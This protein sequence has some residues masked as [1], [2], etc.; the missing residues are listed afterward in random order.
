MVRHTLTRGAF[1]AAMGIALTIGGALPS[2][3]VARAE[4]APSAGPGAPAAAATDTTEEVV[5]PA[6]F[7]TTP[8]GG[9]PYLAERS[10]YREADAAGTEGVFHTE[11]GLAGTQWTRYAD[12]KTVPVTLPD[13]PWTAVQGTG[14]DVLAYLRAG[15]V[16]LRHADGTVRTVALPDGLD[17]GVRV[18]GSTVVAHKMVAKPDGTG[19]TATETHLLSVRPDGTTLD[20]PVTD[21][22]GDGFLGVPYDA[23]D[24]HVLMTTYAPGQAVQPALVSKETGRVT[25]IGAPL[26]TGAYPMALSPRHVA[27]RSADGTVL[28]L[29]RSDLAAPPVPV[30]L[31][32]ALAESQQVAVV[33]EQLV[34]R[35]TLGK[36]YRQPI[37]GGAAV[38]LVARSTQAL[39]TGPDG[40]AV[41]I[42]GSG[43]TDW[44]VRRI[45][46][47]AEGRPV[48]ALVK[49]FTP[50]TAHIRGIAITQGRLA[51]VDDSASAAGKAGAHV[52][53]VSAAGIGERARFAG[54]LPA[55]A[56]D[57]TA[58][59]RLIGLGDG[60]FARFSA[61]DQ[62]FDTYAVAGP[63]RSTVATGEK[64]SLLTDASPHQLLHTIPGPTGENAV[65]D[66]TAN[67]LR[68]YPP[69][70]T[71]LHGSANWAASTTDKGTVVRRFV[72]DAD[73]IASYPGILPCVAQELQVVGRWMYWLCGPNGPAGVRDM[74]TGA[75]RP[76]PSGEALLGDGYV[77]THDKTAGKLV[78]TGVDSSRT[79]SRVIGDL[80]DTG[81][82]Q[83]HIRWT[84]D[85]FGGGAAYVDAA[86][87]VRLVPA[88]IATQPLSVVDG[89]GAD[90]VDAT[91][92]APMLTTLT[93]SK[94]V[95]SWNLSIRHNA[96]GEVTAL[97]AGGEARERI[98]IRWNGRDAAENPMR[99][100][101][102][103]WTFTARP[104]DGVGADFSTSGHTV[105]RNATP[106]ASE[107]FTGVTPV[108]VMDTRTGLGVT[109]AKIG[110]RGTATLTI[111]GKGGVPATGVTAVVMNVTATNTTASTYITAY[112]Y[113]TTRT[114]ASHLN[115]PAGRTVPN[116][117]VVPVR[118]GKVTFY[119]HAGTADLVADVQGYYTP[120]S[121]DLF[122]PLTPARLLDTRS[123]LGAAKG[124]LPGHRTLALTVEGRGG[125]PA[126][127]R[128]VVLNVTAA[129]PTSST[130]VS[131]VPQDHTVDWWGPSLLNTTAGRTVSNVVVAPVVNGKVYLYNH[132]GAVDL[133]ADVQG[134]YTDAAHGSRFEPLA[135]SRVLDTRAG[136]GA[137]KAKVGPGGTVQ[138]TV[139]G[140]AGVSA[141]DV[142]AVVLNVT[143]TNTTA[144]TFITAY[145]YGTTRTSAS[146]VNVP[147]GETVSNLV[148]VPVVD[149]KVTF[150]NHAGSV[151][152]VADVQG[153][154]AR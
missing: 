92:A 131:V 103:T 1:A 78:L 85:R 148:V 59:A 110:A 91:A 29:P 90:A 138:L 65:T 73:A 51:V 30:D 99:N 44:G 144:S 15:E 50:L 124:K 36:V 32:P 13:T 27:L 117:V 25:R 98:D 128:S 56:A 10:R 79:V 57:D 6:A 89:R 130:V 37:A 19:R 136:T 100:G 137:A 49:R 52:R 145:P 69:G 102:Y 62:A 114:S 61:H 111:G 93:L 129:G 154:F 21:A 127:A 113:G 123:G 140:K 76:V 8:R 80:P 28:L 83:R 71:A 150:S 16:E 81:V 14:S 3:T 24:T 55:C 60:R 70:A 152:L 26:P 33:G 63:G 45:T 67:T 58:C 72:L 105:L 119:N 17:G 68:K 7:K 104:V 116:L 88:G 115:V 9:T 23:D 139:A 109:K 142:T 75:S 4:E 66:L 94:P 153:Y 5:V 126:G 48:A 53:T 38:E 87:R 20:L 141:V 134:Y 101:A 149:G 146:N 107:T 22:A 132:A 86:E 39:S 121:G 31:G 35:D 84:V 135:P 118:D 43:S 11:E 143:A 77:V 46:A 2:A 54:Q 47:D 125:V 40:T 42:G 18:F 112:P 108:R 74:W 120:D 95:A 151:D 96:T 97:A 12:G 64:G 82:S 122:R 147:A 133:I 41:V 34:Y 106:T